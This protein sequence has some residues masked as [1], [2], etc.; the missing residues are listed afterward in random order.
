MN[1]EDRRKILERLNSYE[2]EGLSEEELRWL[3]QQERE[4]ENKRQRELWKEYR[5]PFWPL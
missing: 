2:G 5:P 1:E 3:N 4:D